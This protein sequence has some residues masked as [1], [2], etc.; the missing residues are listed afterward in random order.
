MSE[1]ENGLVSFDVM[2]QIEHYEP[3]H[4][5]VWRCAEELLPKLMNVPF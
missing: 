2:V 5:F 4:I 1:E 3:V